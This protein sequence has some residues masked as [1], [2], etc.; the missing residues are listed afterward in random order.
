MQR[1]LSRKTNEN[2][3]DLILS[4]AEKDRVKI[5]EKNMELFGLDGWTNKVLSSHNGYISGS[6]LLVNNPD[7]MDIYVS[8]RMF[9]YFHTHL[10]LVKGYI[11]NTK[12]LNNNEIQVRDDPWF[13]ALRPLVNVTYDA[14]NIF[15]VVTYQNETLNKSID[16]ILCQN[17]PLFTISQ[18]DLTCNIGFYNGKNVWFYHKLKEDCYY[19]TA[20]KYTEAQLK[21]SVDRI[22]KYKQR[23]YKISNKKI[24]TKPIYFQMLGMDYII[25]S[26]LYYNPQ[27]ICGVPAY[28]DAMP[29]QLYPQVP[30]PV[31]PELQVPRM[32]L[33]SDQESESPTTSESSV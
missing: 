8:K 14:K 29:E 32:L 28:L 12:G 1:L 22:Q 19:N 20:N 3:T 25:K 7:D 10:T 18:F 4:E 24:D 21:T 9:R 31:T 33:E 17:H 15:K 26:E 11:P 13:S 2:V 30:T 16:L 23:G 27:K 5:I 6:A